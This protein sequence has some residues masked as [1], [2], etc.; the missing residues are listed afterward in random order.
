MAKS[1]DEL[2]DEVMTPESRARGKERAREKLR[3]YLLSELR[4]ATGVS[5]K[6]L[7]DRMGIRQPTLSKL[8]RKSD[9]QL[10]TLQRIVEGLG[11][12]LVLVADLPE[13]GQVQIKQ[14]AAS[15]SDEQ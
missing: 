2:C 10:S 15:A 8:E 6:E 3:D 13:L 4:E 1:F 5:Q 14:L 12:K 7:A 11:G 9:L